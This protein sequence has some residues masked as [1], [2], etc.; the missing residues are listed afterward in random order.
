MA[1]HRAG[2][3]GLWDSGPSS[4]IPSHPFSPAPTN[5]LPFQLLNE[6]EFVQGGGYFGE[7][8]EALMQGFPRINDGDTKGFHPG[9]M[10]T[11]EMFPSWPMGQQ[12]RTRGNS[13][14]AENSETE[15]S[16]RRRDFA[17][18]FPEKQGDQQMMN[19]GAWKAEAG[20]EAN[21]QPGLQEKMKLSTGKD[22]K[23][24]DAKTLRRLAQNREAARKSRLRKKAYVQQLENSRMKL[25]QLEQHLQRTSSQGLLLVGATTSGSISSDANIFNMDYTRWLEKNYKHMTNLRDGLYA[26]LPDNNLQVIV[27]ECLMHYDEIFQLKGIV[28]KYD[29]FHL[30]T[31]MWATPVERCFLWIGGFRPSELLKILMPYVDPL[32]ESQL[33]GFCNLKH[34][35]QQ[36]EDALSQGIEQLQ[37]SLAKT[38]AGASLSMSEDGNLDENYMGYMTMALGKL[39]KLEGFVKQADHLRQQ[40][41]HQLRRIL[42]IRQAARCLLA[43]GEYNSRLRDLSSLWSSGSRESSRKNERP[44]FTTEANLHI[45]QQTIYAHFLPSN[46]SC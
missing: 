42:T 34:S 10:P 8:E 31:G 37:K 12:Q 15:H 46:S 38:L 35:S 3:T 11:L 17:E 28:V 9:R 13:Q 45:L 30:I 4:Q 25:A 5:F 36:A 22:G 44:F 14:S 32:T 39:S 1:D 6:M 2:E 19:C 43:M 40:I 23:N 18:L 29:V 41:L 33:V 27:D 21:Q 7:L 24:V 26:N 16:V 20:E